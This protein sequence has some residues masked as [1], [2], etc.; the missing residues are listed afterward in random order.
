MKPRLSSI[1][2]EAVIFTVRIHAQIAVN[3]IQ[4]FDVHVVDKPHLPHGVLRT[5]SLKSLVPLGRQSIGDVRT[6]VRSNGR[7]VLM[8]PV[9][10]TIRKTRFREY[11][12]FHEKRN[13][14]FLTIILV[15]VGRLL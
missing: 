4:L 11:T 7:L 13:T 14:L 10:N 9:L 2:T 6:K 12:E 3:R 8:K 5:R 1:D 15:V